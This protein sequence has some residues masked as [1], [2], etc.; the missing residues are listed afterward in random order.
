MIAPTLVLLL[1]TAVIV[2][3]GVAELLDTV[4]AGRAPA[5]VPGSG[6]GVIDEQQGV[7][8]VGRWPALAWFGLAAFTVL[9]PVA[10][11]D[12][13]PDLDGLILVVLVLAFAAE[14]AYYV[15]RRRHTG[16][17]RALRAEILAL[18]FG[19]LGLLVGLTL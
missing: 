19:A 9:A 4:R 8:D 1:C 10:A 2:V 6:S 11:L 17:E 15:V 12:R 18:V 13:R 5:A 14:R 16:D 7:A 3:G